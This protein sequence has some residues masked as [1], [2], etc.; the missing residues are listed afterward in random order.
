MDKFP[1]EPNDFISLPFD[2]TD[3]DIESIL[4]KD[5]KDVAEILDKL[6]SREV[7]ATHKFNE[8]EIKILDA[9]KNLEKAYGEAEDRGIHQAMEII[10]DQIKLLSALL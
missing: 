5:A 9:I 7:E 2:F 10:N 6:K 3:D 1:H 4:A 8:I